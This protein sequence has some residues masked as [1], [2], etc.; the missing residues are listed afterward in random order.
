MTETL[1]NF[2]WEYKIK[3]NTS[4]RFSGNGLTVVCLCVCARARMCASVYVC[5]VKLNICPCASHFLSR[6]LLKRN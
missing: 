4:D 5:L 6:Y 1:I 3:C 2:G